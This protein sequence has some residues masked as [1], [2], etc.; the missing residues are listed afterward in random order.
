MRKH[1]LIASL[2]ILTVVGPARASDR[3][4]GHV[5]ANVVDVRPTT[6]PSEVFQASQTVTGSW[7]PYSPIWN[8]LSCCRQ[9]NHKKTHPWDVV[10]DYCASPD[11][12]A[13]VATNSCSILGFTSETN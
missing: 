1:L 3:A 2:L 6:I 4:I 13:W 5:S 12:T 10:S 7:I 9:L 11:I 8:L